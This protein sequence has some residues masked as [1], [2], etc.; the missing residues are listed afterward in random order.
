MKYLN[1]LPIALLSG[2]AQWFPANV[3]EIEEGVFIVS[4]V[5]NSFA[6]LEAMKKDY[7][8]VLSNSY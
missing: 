6:S 4:A 8:T 3:Q 7:T 1:L 5:G 2:C